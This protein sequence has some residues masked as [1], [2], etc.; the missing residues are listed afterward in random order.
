MSNQETFVPLNS[1]FDW[2]KDTIDEPETNIFTKGS[3]I[4]EWTTSNV[5]VLGE[6]GSKLPIYFELA[7]QNL[8]GVSGIWPFGTPKEDQSNG[9]LEGFQHCYPL[10]STK[11]VGKPTKAERITHERFHKMWDITVDAIKCFSEYRKVPAPTYSAYA[12]AKE[13]ND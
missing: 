12:T 11:T 1:N 3:S 4:I 10:T 7:E 5:Y 13:E 6:N 9:K 8:W 2:S